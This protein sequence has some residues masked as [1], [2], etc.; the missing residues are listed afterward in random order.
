VG[1]RTIT[2][3]DA[4][5]E[6][7]AR[8]KRPGESFTDVILRLTGQRSLRDLPALVTPTEARALA[9]ALLAARDE[10][11]DARRRRA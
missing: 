2:V 5:Y 11:R 7:L 3:T 1:V 4:A 9:E 8:E 6:R 10:R